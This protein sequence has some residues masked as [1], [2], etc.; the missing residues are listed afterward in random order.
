MHL[1]HA[2]PYWAQST[3]Q[4]NVLSSAENVAGVYDISVR[5]CEEGSLKQVKLNFIFY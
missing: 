2:R 3:P 4:S 1:V 5:A